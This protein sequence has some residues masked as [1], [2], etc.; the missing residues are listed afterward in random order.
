MS[1]YQNHCCVNTERNKLKSVRKTLQPRFENKSFSPHYICWKRA[2]L[3]LLTCSSI[4]SICPETQFLS[5]WLMMFLCD[6]FFF[7]LHQSLHEELPPEGT[8][9]DAH[10][11]DHTGCNVDADV[12]G[13]V[14]LTDVFTVSVPSVRPQCRSVTAA[15]RLQ[16]A[17]DYLFI[18][19][20]FCNVASFDP[21]C[22]YNRGHN[23]K[24]NNIKETLVCSRVFVFSSSML[25]RARTCPPSFPREGEQRRE[26]GGKRKK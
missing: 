11:W 14:P 25:R 17:S 19:C 5:S 24:E 18:F 13:N 4:C 8:P 6:Y 12:T 22:N 1:F 21:P 23:E 16:L 15:L 10:R 20:I 26:G 2:P 7:R 9:A 3:H